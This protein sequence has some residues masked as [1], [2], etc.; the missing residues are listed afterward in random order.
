MA[1]RKATCK[2][3]RNQDLTDHRALRG[4]LHTIRTASLEER[5]GKGSDGRREKNVTEIETILYN[6]TK[7]L[8]TFNI[9]KQFNRIYRYIIHSNKSLSRRAHV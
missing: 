8:C 1:Q 9:L 6:S 5:H 3:A 2:K 7:A 4:Q